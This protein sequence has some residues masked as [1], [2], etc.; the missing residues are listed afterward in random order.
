MQMR[1]RAAAGVAGQADHLSA[2]H[3]LADARQHAVRLQV[4]VQGHAAVVVQDADEVRARVEVE[5]VLAGGVLVARE[6]ELED[7]DESDGLEIEG[8]ITSVTPAL[9]TFVVRGVTVRHDASTRFKDGTP[10]QL[11]VGAKVEVKGSLSPDGATLLA[12]EVE[13]DD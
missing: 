3:A 1:G 9:N 8:R 6:V 10:A 4:R 12:S 7:D 5:G 2:A 13:F 11:A